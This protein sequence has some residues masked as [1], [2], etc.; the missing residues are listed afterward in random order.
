MNV[1]I[2]VIGQVLLL[3]S[4]IIHIVSGSKNFVKFIFSFSNDWEPLT[5][6]AQFIQ[7]DSS[8]IVDIGND[9]V[10]YLPEPITDGECILSLYGV[11]GVGGS[12]IA[13]T[14]TLT[15]N[16]KKSNYIEDGSEEIFE[17]SIA[18]VEEVQAYMT[19]T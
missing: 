18:T 3:N 17:D 5:K 14:N 1:L 9:R 10:C 4:N 2:R 13:T 12:T 7:G 16:I 11:G 8:Y 6:Y 19:Q 15:F